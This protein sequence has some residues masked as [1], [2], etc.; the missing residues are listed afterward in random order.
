MGGHFTLGCGLKIC[1]VQNTG[2]KHGE[3]TPVHTYRH[4]STNQAEHGSFCQPSTLAPRAPTRHHLWERCAAP[5]HSPTRPYHIIRSVMIAPSIESYNN[6]NANAMK[7]ILPG[8]ILYFSYQTLVAFYAD[9]EM[10]ISRNEWGVTTGKHLNLI[11]KG[12]N[13]LL[14]KRIPHAD[15]IA[16][17]LKRF[18]HFSLPT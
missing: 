15:L 3:A 10:N 11:A 2:A 18:P 9:H 13:P 17:F 8:A 7:V 12:A 6:N 16:K 4:T 5:L 1:R 14:V